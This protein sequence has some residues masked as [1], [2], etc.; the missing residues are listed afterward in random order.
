M[1][2]LDGLKGINEYPVKSATFQSVATKRGLSLD[3]ELTA[4]IME[5]GSYKL[6]TADIYVALAYSPNVSQGGVSVSFTDEQRSEFLSLANRLYAEFGEA[7]SIQ[8]VSYGYK[9]SDL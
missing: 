9:G 2:V 3:G 6:A 1:T 8:G 7:G 5:G 4:E